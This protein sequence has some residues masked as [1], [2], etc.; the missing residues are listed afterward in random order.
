MVDRDRITGAPRELGG[1]VQGA[2]GDLAGSNRDSVEGRLREAQGTAENLYG[3]AK[4]AVRH[5]VDEV[6]D[7]AAEAYDR[8]RHYAWESHQKSVEWPH[9]SLVVAGLVGFGLGLLISRL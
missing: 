2:V 8:G 1:K 5:A 4:D 9:A 7:H 3:Q 6:S